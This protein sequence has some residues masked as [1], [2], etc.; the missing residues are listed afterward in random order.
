MTTA[1]SQNSPVRLRTIVQQSVGQMSMAM[2]THQQ[3]KEEQ[4]VTIPMSIQQINPKIV[5]VM[6]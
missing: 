2:V 1:I 5:I 3:V 4:T 6:E